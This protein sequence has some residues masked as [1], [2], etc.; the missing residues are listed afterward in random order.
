MLS[1]DGVSATSRAPHWKLKRI[2]VILVNKTNESNKFEQNWAGHQA[3]P[4]SS[5][6]SRRHCW[7]S[8]AFSWKV[9][10]HKYQWISCLPPADAFKT[11]C[12][13]PPRKSLI[14]LLYRCQRSIFP[15]FKPVCFRI[16]YSYCLN[17]QINDY[18]FSL[19]RFLQQ[20]HFQKLPFNDYPTRQL[21]L[22]PPLLLQPHALHK[23]WNSVAQFTILWK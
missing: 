18:C 7:T 6:F 12:S 13:L 17:C 2:S 10:D 20:N 1:C 19:N 3:Q 21:Y 4:I 8:G 16:C 11:L 22:N 23:K 9:L 15:N 5:F 14:A